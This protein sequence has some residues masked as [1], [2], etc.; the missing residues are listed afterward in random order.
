MLDAQVLDSE[1]PEISP[2]ADAAQEL[3]TVAV[4]GLGYVGLPVAVEFGKRRRTI[5]YDLPSKKVQRLKQFHDATGGGSGDDLRAA[6]KLEVT[7]DPERIRDADFVIIAVPTPV[8]D[9]RQPD[10]SPLEGASKIVGKHLKAGAT[11]I[12]ESTVYPGTTE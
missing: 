7:D 3:P 2:H 8:N 1:L 9:A 11:V 6:A 12:Y 4:V 5:G 10:F